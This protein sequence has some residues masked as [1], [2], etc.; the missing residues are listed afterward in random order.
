MKKPDR[1]EMPPVGLVAHDHAACV[2]SALAQAETRCAQEGLRMTPVR[3]RTLEILLESHVAMGAYDVLARLAAEGLGDKP[4]VAYRALSFLVEHGF[5][6]RI[7][8][9]N[10]FVAC[11]HPGESHEAVFLICRKCH[12][13]GEANLAQP[14]SGEIGHDGFRV[15]R[16]VIE[17][18]GLCPDCQRLEAA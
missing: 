12:K 1:Q 18:E 17:A 7:E 13:V 15:E 2:A 10:A 5:A 11:S 9:L 3:R 4:P 8:K 16:M 14:I 6:H